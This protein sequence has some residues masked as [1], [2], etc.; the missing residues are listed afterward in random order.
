M[1]KSGKSGG[2][3]KPSGGVKRG[4]T[5]APRAGGVMPNPRTPKSPAM[6]KAS[7]PGKQG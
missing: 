5:R 4:T 6:G 3:G 2:A 1:A 7:R